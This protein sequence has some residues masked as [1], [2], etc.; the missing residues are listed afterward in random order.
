MAT[1]AFL[2]RWRMMA[3]GQGAILLKIDLTT[4][5]GLSS[6]SIF[7]SQGEIQT[8]AGTGIATRLWEDLIVDAPSIQDDG[9]FLTNDVPLTSARFTLARRKLGFQAAG[10]T[11]ADAL[12]DYRWDQSAAVTVYLWERGLASFDDAMQRFKGT[13][14]TFDLDASGVTLYCR[15][16]ADWNKTIA[17]TVVT[18]GKYVRAPD[19]SVGLA[20]P[21]IYGAKRGLPMRPPFTGQYGVEQ[22]VR[23]LIA[24]GSR[25][26]QA[27]LVD[28]GR[29]VG[30]SV[31]DARVLVASHAVTQ[32]GVSSPEYMN[33][34]HYGTSPFI[35][36]DDGRLHP[37]FPLT[38][39]IF[40]SGADG[41][42][43]EI[44]DGFHVAYYPIMPTSMELV[45]DCTIDAIA[46]LDGMNETSFAH[47]DAGA[48]Q[49]LIQARLPSLSDAGA[50]WSGS[51]F[52]IYRSSAG[53]TGLTF[54]F[55]NTIKASGSPHTLPVSVTPRSYNFDIVSGL[56]WGGGD[57]P[58]LS[59][60]FADCV[61]K[62]Y[63][64]AGSGTFDVFMM[65]LSIG[66][67]VNKNVIQSERVT[68]RMIRRKRSVPTW[69]VN[70]KR[71]IYKTYSEP[72]ILPP[73]TELQGT[74]F[75]NVD[76]YPDDGSGTYTGSASALIER[77]PDIATHLLVNQ[78]GQTIAQIERG[79]SVFGSLVDARAKL[80]TWRGADMKFTIGFGDDEDVATALM[81]L[82]HSSASWFYLS[83]YDDKWKCVVW[84]PD[85]VVDYAW[86]FSK[87][88][89]LEPAGPLCT[90]RPATELPAG[91]RVTYGYDAATKSFLHESSVAQGK[92]VA[93]HFYRN[94]RDGNTT[95]VSSESDRVDFIP[96]G[97][98]AKV[99]SLTPGAYTPALLAAHVQT[100]MKAADTS[101]DY[102]WA[103]GAEVVSGVN[104]SL[105]F[106]SGATSYIAQLNPGDYGTMAALAVEAARALNAVLA[107]WTATYSAT[108]GKFTLT[109][110]SSVTLKS[111]TGTARYR[112]AYPLLGFSISA[113]YTGT[114][115]V[116]DIERRLQ[117]M[118]FSGS[119]LTDLPWKT[120]T[121]AARNAAELL[122]FDRNEDTLH[123]GATRI[124][125]SISPKLNIE[126][127]IASDIDRIGP[128]R[129]LSIEARA[130]DDTDTAREIRNRIATLSRRQSLQVIF[131]TEKAPDIQRGNVIAFQADMDTVLPFP[132]PDSDGSWVGKRF[133]VTEI[134][135]LLGPLSFKTRI[136]ATCLSRVETTA[137][138]A[139]P[140]SGA[141]AVWRDGRVLN[142]IYAQKL[143]DDGAPLW[144]VN[145]V[146][147]G[148]ND[149]ATGSAVLSAAVLATS[150][151]GAIVAYHENRGAT[152][153]LYVQRFRSDGSKLWDP[154]GINLC[155]NA[156]TPD[157]IRICTDGA[158]GAIVAWVDSR[159]GVY[160]LYLQRVNSIGAAQWTANGVAITSGA[161]SG[162]DFGDRY[163]R[164]FPLAAGGCYVTWMKDEYYSGIDPYIWAQ[165]VNGS[166]VIQWAVGGV[167]IGHG[168]QA[169]FENPAIQDSE[170]TLITGHQDRLQ[171]E[172]Y[173][174]KVSAAG[175]IVFDS[176]IEAN[177]SNYVEQQELVSDGAGGAFAIWFGCGATYGYDWKLSCRRIDTYGALIGAAATTIY[178]NSG[179]ASLSNRYYQ[180]P[181]PD[182]E[183]GFFVVFRQ[184]T[185]T[186]PSIYAAR[187][188]A[189]CALVWGP[190]LLASGQINDYPK[191]ASDNV[192]G[193][194]AAWR[195][196]LGGD[197]YA[198][199]VS[200]SGALLWAAG[201]VP[202]VAAAGTADEMMVA[203][204]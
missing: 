47:I 173:A 167:E 171:H 71:A 169:F 129:D 92:S 73:I 6:V 174:R 46:V 151:G 160:R 98:A 186:N 189:S 193:L 130:V 22:R 153:D 55:G 10:K 94:L 99:A 138:V 177:S 155:N 5:D 181:I 93:G 32:L 102:V 30:S 179:Y 74:F 198:Q 1:A 108:T 140:E 96:T 165:K 77:A 62:A 117:F 72:E 85:A 61:L 188:N 114:S 24:G 16:R 20:I 97:I 161:S 53:A 162:D 127:Q 158:D 112:S 175:M 154:S 58:D 104:D 70:G 172:F 67:L 12:R 29:G 66:Y 57:L 118:T 122:G 8:P 116:S 41:A 191:A 90:R 204:V 68:G 110:P 197:W 147:V 79:A 95:I 180:V 113:N 196:Q 144:P 44:P 192:G 150:D 86:A 187:V 182:G 190:T 27:I 170:G 89:I 83:P 124:W 11:I 60:C 82:A 39:D 28:N 65:G 34:S 84:D 81:D 9:D 2:A 33:P 156:Y 159:D 168:T 202:I 123:G 142:Q 201:G 132:D 121:N 107:G 148:A 195:R 25:V 78:A 26:T 42:G 133:V 14:L 51:A 76:G 7:A 152:N 128:K 19:S 101:R 80:K 199:R 149:S 64:L 106:L 176:V 131:T 48:S 135:Q 100:Q 88:D 120:G 203:S 164:L 13:I 54:D 200:A 3:S 38:A 36:A 56:N 137:S 40:L 15:Q 157:D 184:T 183:G 75:T 91:I 134:E 194:I 145:G 21:K 115:F 139:I 35:R 4:R 163:P 18:R 17:A 119:V 178:T 185:G 111:N 23:E 69:G 146:V 103:Y 43:F 37:L 166:G 45:T 50:L 126:E 125:N 109:P 31:P 143:D 59:W 63:F 52:I 136:S 49:H 105:D 87:H 141:L